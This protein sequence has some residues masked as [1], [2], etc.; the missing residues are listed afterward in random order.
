MR[1]TNRNKCVWNGKRSGSHFE[2]VAY[3]MYKK[4]IKF[5]LVASK[6]R[7][8]V[9]EGAHVYA[10]THQDAKKAVE[11]MMTARARKH[12]HPKAMPFN[13]I[14]H[15][16]HAIF[17]TTWNM[18]F[19]IQMRMFI[20]W[21][22]KKNIFSRPQ[23]VHRL[24]ILRINILF[25]VQDTTHTHIHTSYIGQHKFS[26]ISVYLFILLFCMEHSNFI[27]SIIIT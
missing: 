15:S 1:S 7:K 27:I 23:L 8:K 12:N 19:Q 17:Y 5:R 3:V 18:P 13:S 24:H 20:F 11:Q 25:I 9:T 2:W 10:Q 21:W 22:R 16:L 4:F 6:R 14:S 26:H